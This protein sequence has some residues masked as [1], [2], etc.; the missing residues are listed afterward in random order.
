MKITEMRVVFDDETRGSAT[1]LTEML[2]AEANH[3]NDSLSIKK[4]HLKDVK[5]NAN[6]VFIVFEKLI[7]DLSISNIEIVDNVLNEKEIN[8]IISKY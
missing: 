8:G 2:K 4:T 1:M 3:M 5:D 7:G 6:A